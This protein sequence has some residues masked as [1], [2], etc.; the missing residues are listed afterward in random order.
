[1]RSEVF[2][3]SAKKGSLALRQ[4]FFEL[5]KFFYQSVVLVSFS[6]IFS[7]GN[8]KNAVFF[9]DRTLAGNY[10][11]FDGIELIAEKIKSDRIVEIGR[12]KVD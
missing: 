2:Q 3:L 1:M 5:G 8:D 6:N 12:K 4:V 9:I 7:G 11:F 10:E